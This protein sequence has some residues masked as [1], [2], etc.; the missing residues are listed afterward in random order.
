MNVYIQ[1]ASYAVLPE[2]QAKEQ[3]TNKQ[4]QTLTVNAKIC[5][6]KAIG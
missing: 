4:K 5:A 2:K 6:R 1:K 3:K